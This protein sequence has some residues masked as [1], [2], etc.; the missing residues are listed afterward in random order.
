L[1]IKHDP[2]MTLRIELM[3]RRFKEHRKRLG[4]TRYRISKEAHVSY[5]ALLLWD[6]GQILPATRTALKVGRLLGLVTP[7]MENGL[8]LQKKTEEARKYYL[9]HREK[10][11]KY[12]FKPKTK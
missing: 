2:F 5:Y 4:Y 12:G 6:R 10:Y 9:E 8:K 7:E 1:T 11:A 3:G